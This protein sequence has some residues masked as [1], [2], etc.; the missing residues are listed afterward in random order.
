MSEKELAAGW[1]WDRFL[2]AVLHFEHIGTKQA[3]RLEHRAIETVW[4]VETINSTLAEDGSAMHHN[5]YF[6]IMLSDAIALAANI[7]IAS[8]LV[9][10]RVVNIR[11]A[12][13]AETDVFY[14]VLNHY[15]TPEPQAL[16]EAEAAQLAGGRG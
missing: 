10:E 4:V 1:V 16:S 2:G 8:Q 9:A 13:Q 12:T 15:D 11:R 6:A 14:D 5:C 3:E 7:Q